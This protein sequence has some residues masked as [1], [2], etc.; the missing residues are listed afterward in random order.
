MISIETVKANGSYTCMG[1]FYLPVLA[2]FLFFSFQFEIKTLPKCFLLNLYIRLVFHNHADRKIDKVLFIVFLLL[3][4]TAET[5]MLF[6]KVDRK[7]ISQLA[8]LSNV[9]Q[10][11]VS[12]HLTLGE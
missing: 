12:Q 7:N 2:I 10:N 11:S 3:L 5:Q 9:F 8:N 6:L 1:I 4:L